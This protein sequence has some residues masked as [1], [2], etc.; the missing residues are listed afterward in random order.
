M[1]DGPSIRSGGFIKSPFIDMTG[2]IIGELLVIEYVARETQ[3]TINSDYDNHFW[4]CRHLGCDHGPFMYERRQIRGKAQPLCPICKA[5]RQTTREANAAS[6]RVM[7]RAIKEELHRVFLMNIKSLFETGGMTARAIGRALGKSEGVVSYQL[8][9]M[10]LSPRKVYL[11]KLKVTKPEQIE[12]RKARK[13][14]QLRA[15]QAAQRQARIAAGAVVNANGRIAK[16]ATEEEAL[17][18]RR[19]SGRKAYCANLE[20]NRKRERDRQRLKKGIPLD[21]P[22]NMKGLRR[23]KKPAVVVL[24]SAASD[25]E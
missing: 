5:K 7:Q 23:R 1:A 19:A 16:Y 14:Q 22:I 25:F 2:E 11:G 10:G 13:R 12:E 4:F 6:S 18:A 24:R 17:A 3:V 9:Q 8:R 21:L 15:W 20:E